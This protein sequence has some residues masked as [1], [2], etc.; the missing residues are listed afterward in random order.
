[1]SL[2]ILCINADATGK[3]HAELYLNTHNSS[4]LHRVTHLKNSAFLYEIDSLQSQYL[5]K[6]MNCQHSEAMVC[7]CSFKRKASLFKPVVC[8][9]NKEWIHG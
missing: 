5:P 9:K 3:S 2:I 8:F 4:C 6:I 1:M 7:N